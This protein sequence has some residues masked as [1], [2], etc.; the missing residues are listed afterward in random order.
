MGRDSI[1]L[2]GL[3]QPGARIAVHVTPGASR[4]RVVAG[5]PLRLYVTARPEAGRATTAAR[6]LLAAAMGVAKTRLVLERGTTSR[7]KVFRLDQG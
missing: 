3:A 5:D 7:Q 4:N 6:D 1:D 2:S